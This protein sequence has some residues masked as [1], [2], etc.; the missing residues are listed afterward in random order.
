[1]TGRP[2]SSSKATRWPPKSF[3]A[4][5]SAGAEQCFTSADRVIVD[6]DTAAN[7]AARKHDANSGAKPI[8][9]TSRVW[10]VASIIAIGSNSTENDF[11]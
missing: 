9:A 8:T 2:L 5:E 3:S 1:M 11:V 7:A 4:S 6:N 10:K